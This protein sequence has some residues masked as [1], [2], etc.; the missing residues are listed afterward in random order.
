[1]LK[2]IGK[3]KQIA[4]HC[5][6]GQELPKDLSL[7]LGM[8]LQRFLDHEC[9]SLNDALELH[10]D[11]GGVPWWMEEAIRVRDAALR[12]LADLCAPGE[13]KSGMARCVHELTCRYAASAWRFDALRDAMPP[14]YADTPKEHLWK[15]FRSG[16][17]MP[18]SERQL[19]NILQD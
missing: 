7:W 6:S 5:M 16:A 2:E 15:A 3:L 4:H 1:M 17:A 11:R 10:T 13:G 18:I 19:R 14:T 8:G 9:R 12:E